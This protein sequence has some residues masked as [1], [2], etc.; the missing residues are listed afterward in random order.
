MGLAVGKTIAGSPQPF[1]KIPI[2]W[3][4]RALWFSRPIFEIV[5]NG[6]VEGQQLRYCGIGTGYDDIYIQGNPTEMKFVAYYI[7]GGQVTA[8]AR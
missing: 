8:V 4:A 5:S 3:S 1:V 2:F 7:E 6:V